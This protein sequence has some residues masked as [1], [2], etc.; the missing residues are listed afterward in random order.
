MPQWSEQAGRVSQSFDD[1]ILIDRDQRAFLAL[2]LEF[3][4]AAYEGIWAE[5]GEE[6]G[7][8][9]GSE[10]IDLFEERVEGL[11]Q[12][13]YEWMYCGGVLR[14]AVTNFEVYLEKAREEVLRHQGQPTRIS[15]RSLSWGAAKKF[16]KRIGAE[17]DGEEVE[18]VRDLRHF[19]T[20][21]RGELRTKALRQKYAAE[22]DGIGPINAELSAAK[23]ITAM[24][25]L[26]A[27][28][29]AVDVQA[30]A[31]SWGGGNLTS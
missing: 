27:A 10:Q 20:H 29:R 11:H 26:G 23:V 22:A 15:D 21:R 1:W 31:Y 6:P 28:V 2:G 8:G 30:Y 4:A 14:E 17:I 24:D 9:D 13:D 18:A 25:V 16:C 5:A 7:D 3:A 19:L 12:H